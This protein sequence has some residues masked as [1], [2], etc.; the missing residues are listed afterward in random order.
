MALSHLKTPK[1]GV[2]KEVVEMPDIVGKGRA[3][4]PSVSPCCVPALALHIWKAF[5]F[6]HL[7]L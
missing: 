2:E 3:G 7:P 4:T 1:C 6:F 5:P